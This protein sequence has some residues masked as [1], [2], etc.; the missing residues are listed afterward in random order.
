MRST[1]FLSL[2][3]ATV[4]GCHDHGIPG[5]G[6]MAVADMSVGGSDMSSDDMSIGDMGPPDDIR[7]YVSFSMFAQSYAETVCQ[8]LVTCGQ[9]DAA[10]MAACVERRKLHTG[11]DQDTE[12]S[13]G[14]MRINDA[15][16]LDAIRTS[17]CD[18]SDSG[19]VFF[20]CL[21]TLY[22]PQQTIGN[23][24]LSSEECVNSY[25]AHSGSDGGAAGV[26]QPGGCP[27]TCAA[28]KAAGAPCRQDTDCGSSGFC[29]Y[30]TST[31]SDFSAVGGPCQNGY[32]VGAGVCKPGLSCESF[33]ATPKCVT[34]STQTALH[35]ACDPYQGAVTPMPSCASG[36]YC[37]LVYTDGAACSASVPCTETGAY[38]DV[39]AGKCKVPTSGSCEMRIAVAQACNPN[40][41]G[42]F[43]YAEDQ[44]V[45]GAVCSLRTGQTS[46]T[47]Q[48]LVSA[49]GSC[50]TAT[51]CK[52]GLSC[53]GGTCQPW[54]A[55]GQA[56][57]T[58]LPQCASL[59][60]AV[61][62]ADAG[63]S[64]TCQAMLDVGQSCM[65]GFGDAVCWPADFPISGAATS[66]CAAAGSGSGTC[67]P[68]CF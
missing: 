21:Q 28:P 66:T 45:D 3:C 6:D 13:K 65:P 43:Y 40:N 38:C 23:P 5:E 8:H 27:G 29:D 24:C 36:M 62:N 57:G 35:G 49:N 44:C 53:V 52:V 17:R 63:T 68:K 19:A 25:C 58:G 26:E 14:R 61:A 16:C 1:L 55:D 20:H 32:F 67:A 10:Q 11:W 41:E 46:Y 2:I 7:H 18:S 51:D 64:T 39:T 60:C 47:C 42:Q 15:Q 37:Q 30:N 33:S 22:T 12:I 56:C 48:A 50:A 59:K 31:C 9:L 4:A 34:P 54:G